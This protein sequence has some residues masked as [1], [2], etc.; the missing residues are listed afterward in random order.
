MGNIPFLFPDAQKV[1]PRYFTYGYME[2]VKPPSWQ[3]G[4]LLLMPTF[5]WGQRISNSG[6]RTSIA[7]PQPPSLIFPSFL[8]INRTQDV[9]ISVTKL[10]GRHTLKGGFYLNHSY[11]AQTLGVQGSFNFWGTIDFGND[12]NNPIDSGFGYAN[13]ALGIF[14]SYAQ[15]SKMLEGN[16]LYNNIEGYAQDNWKVSRSLTLDYGLRFTR[17]QPQYDGFGQASNFFADKWNLAQA[18][19]LYGA[20][21]PN[22]VNPCTSANRQALDPRTGQ[23]LGAN[24]ATFIGA[25]VPNTGNA[26]NGIIKNGDGIAKENYVW[27]SVVLGPRFGV[28]YDLRGDQ[29]MVVRG[30][31]GLFYDR[32][33]GNSIYN[34]ISNPPY[35]TA[36]TVRYGQLQSL[37]SSAAVQTAPTLFIFQYNAKVPSSLQWNVGTQ[38]ALPWSA[39]LDLSYVAQRGINLLRSQASTPTGTNAQDINAVDFGAAYLPQNQDPTLAASTVPGATAVTTDLLRPYR[40]L[41]AINIQWPRN[42]DL[43]HSFQ[44]SL[45]RRFRNGL[46]FGV[47]YTLGLSYTGTTITPLRLQHAADGSFSI[48]AD[49]ADQDQLLNNMGLQK[50]TVK[51]SFVWDMPD[52]AQTGGLKTAVA[53]LAND[54]QLSGILTAGSPVPYDMSY[55]Y[56]TGGDN[57]NLTGSPSYGARVKIVGDPGSGCSGNQYQQ[58]NPAAFAGPTYGSVGLESGRFYMP[59]C[60]DHTVDMAL[61]RNFRI[62]GGRNIQLRADVFNVFNAVVYNAR[63]TQLQLTNPVDQVVRNSQFNADGTLNTARLQPRNAGFGAATGAQTMRSVQFQLRFQ[64]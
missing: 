33:E 63:V 26:L 15:Q 29:K 4:Q 7:A 44:A 12:T 28:A 9:S 59:G 13:A 34:E 17:Q 39:V 25:I 60:P 48:R 54:W 19:L 20:G 52:L 30:A 50:H 21:C 24:T 31:L 10:A 18:P 55:A 8:N 41:G 47:N 16:Y 53:L 5:L 27:P 40:G 35:S 56:Q 42:H 11:K 22:N 23:L 6:T 49:Q 58:F 43:Y 37:S 32:P 51:A 38:L 14:S 46:Q 3:N 2:A 36:S 62:M 64:F 45:N 57:V 1:D 61:A